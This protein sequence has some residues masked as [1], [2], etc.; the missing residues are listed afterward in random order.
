MGRCSPH[1]QAVGWHH[2]PAPGKA[3][4]SRLPPGRHPLRTPSRLQP[5]RHPHRTSSCQRNQS[6]P[7]PR[8]APQRGVKRDLPLSDIPAALWKSLSTKGPLSTGPRRATSCPAPRVG[9][10]KPSEGPRWAHLRCGDTSSVQLILSD[11]SLR[12]NCPGHSLAAPQLGGLSQP[13]AEGSR[14][15]FFPLFAGVGAD[16]DSKGTHALSPGQ[17][18]SQQQQHRLGWSTSSWASQGRE[19]GGWRRPKPPRAR[20]FVERETFPA[21]SAKGTGIPQ[22]SSATQGS[23]PGPCGS[24]QDGEVSERRNVGCPFW[25]GRDLS[26]S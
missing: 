25:I 10:D 17:G 5:G 19:G 8:A 18:W 11:L 7:F 4:P 6:S 16:S 15:A 13:Q 24:W 22:S 1:C 12:G 23:A 26:R 21:G 2:S 3:A 14:S 9:G 20:V